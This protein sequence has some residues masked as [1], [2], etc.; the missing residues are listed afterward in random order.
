MRLLLI[1]L[2]S[3]SASFSFSQRAS[4]NSFNLSRKITKG[5]L[6]IQSFMKT[7]IIASLLLLGYSAKAQVNHWETVVYED[8]NWKYL[9]P[10]SSVNASWNTIGFNAASW[11]NG[12]G[13]FGY[14]DGDDNTSFGGAISCYQRI[15][16]SILDVNAIEQAV[17]NIDYD[18]AF[19]AYL[20]GV[21]IGRD[22]ITSG[23][24][25]NYN[26]SS[27]GL[28]EAQ[29][30]QG[31]QPNY[32]TLDQA[33]LAANLVNGSNVLCVQAHNEQIGSSDMSSRAWLS[34]AINNTSTNY[35]P[36]PFW[37]IEPLVFLDSD[38]PIVVINTAGGA[39]IP[40]EPKIDATMGIIYNGAGVRNYITDAFNEYNGDIGIELRGSSS[41]GFPKKQWGVETRDNLGQSNDV[42]IFG[43][44][45]DNDWVLQAP[46]SDKSLMRNFLAYDMG[47]DLDE[48]A[49]RT[50]F[51]EVVLNGQYEG[52]YVFMEKI[53]RK[54]GKVGTN[55]L[56]QFDN[57]GNELTGDYVLKVDKLTSGGVVAWY[58]PFSP[59]PGATDQVSFQAHDPSL[60]SLTATQLNYIENHITSW[61][62][63]LDGPNFD[64]PITG[65]APYVDMLSFVDFFLVNEISKNVDGYRISSFLHKIRTSE[66]GNIVAGP[67]WD[68]NLAYG[69]ADYCVAG[70]TSDWQMDFY[71]IC[72]GNIPFWWRKM[73]QDPT[74]THMLNCRWQEMRLGA[75]HTDSLMAKIDTIAAFLDE[76]QQRNFQRWQIHGQYIWPNNFVGNNF[77]EDVA[78][79][80][81][82]IA[83]RVSWMDANMFG[84][85]P[86]LSL[87]EDQIEDVQVFPNP[88]KEDFNFVFKN[89][90]SNGSI[91]L[92]DL[93]GHVVFSEKGITGKGYKTYV[94]NLSSGMYYYTFDLNGTVVNG[95]L[96]IQQ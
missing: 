61:E 55:D 13:G 51:C 6:L 87:A 41:Q 60:D 84:S 85:C 9:V 62:T 50:K 65:Y 39:S 48:Y 68:F 17:F 33:F 95:K 36:T 75:W 2:I 11:T 74:Y 57:S 47:R 4:N 3:F 34:L 54:D 49:P 35:G 38:L 43:M 30:Y 37:F 93:S 66:G 22:N 76:S 82:W 71:Q 12:Q 83:N 18:D 89:Y 94:E 7:L 90:I 10:T 31:G 15:A 16:F 40:D 32:Y 59:F 69:N 64:N 58:S 56:N 88:A 1:S 19:V 63:A 72:G 8:D 20:N 53:K 52:V 67:L 92:M 86:D 14:G 80:K 73:I 27:D 91:Q 79:M 96:M 81:D 78:Y 25:P 45:F 5:K 23:G 24:Q 46:Y 70:T 42:S 26:Q 28:H 44:A 77:Q 29:M 21:E